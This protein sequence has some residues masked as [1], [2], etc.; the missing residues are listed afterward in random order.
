MTDCWTL[1]ELKPHYG[2]SKEGLSVFDY[3][4]F[5]NHDKKLLLTIQN[6]LETEDSI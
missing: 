2:L 3:G 1:S 4:V 5:L 6:R